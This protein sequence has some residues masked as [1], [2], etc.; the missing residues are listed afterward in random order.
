MNLNPAMQT[1]DHAEYADKQPIRQQGLATEQVRAGS[2]TTRLSRSHTGRGRSPAAA[3]PSVGRVGESESRRGFLAAAAGDRPRSGES[4]RPSDIVPDRGRSASACVD[5]RGCARQSA[6]ERG[7]T[8]WEL[9]YEKDIFTQATK[10]NEARKKKPLFSSFASVGATAMAGW[11]ADDLP[12]S[13]ERSHGNPVQASGS[14]LGGLFRFFSN[15]S[16]MISEISFS[17]G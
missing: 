8:A 12:C 17:T 7:A 1:A 9:N 4:S 14:T 10:V 15:R 13:H 5:H 16:E 6:A 11:E 2:A 3:R